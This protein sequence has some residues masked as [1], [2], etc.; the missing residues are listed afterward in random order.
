MAYFF[1]IFAR[2]VTWNLEIPTDFQS[3]ENHVMVTTICSNNKQQ[4]NIGTISALP[5]VDSRIGKIFF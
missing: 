1:D 5:D 3:Y 2:L 4:G